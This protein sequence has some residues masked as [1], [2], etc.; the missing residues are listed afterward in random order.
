M[1]HVTVVVLLSQRHLPPS[2]DYAADDVVV[3]LLLR[4]PSRRRAPLY[5]G[6]FLLPPFFDYAH[7]APSSSLLYIL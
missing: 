4:R 7:Q 5:Y 1:L 6:T 2:F 3:P